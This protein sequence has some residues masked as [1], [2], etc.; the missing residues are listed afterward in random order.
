MQGAPDVPYVFISYASADRER[1]LAVV[2]ALQRAGV[3]VWIDQSGIPGGALYGAEIAAGIEQAAAMILLCTPVSLA[4]RNVRQEIL[5]GWKFQKSYLPLLLEPCEFPKEMSYWLEG[6][7][8]VEV[9]DAPEAVWLPQA[10]A[11]LQR[12]GIAGVAETEPPASHTPASPSLPPLPTI[13]E[14]PPLFGREREQAALRERL[15]GALGGQGGLVLIGGEAGVGKTALTETVAYE[16]TVRGALVLTGR[17][18][19]LT[20]TPP[21]GPWTEI[22]DSIPAA[23]DL[24]PRPSAA[25]SSAASQAEFFREA[26]VFFAALAD[27]RPLVLVLDDMQ[28]ADPASLDML[29]FLSRS[30]ATL[31]ILLVATYRAEDVTRRH[32]FYTLLPILLREAGA[33]RLDLH[34]LPIADVETLVTDRYRLSEADATRLVAYLHERAGGNAFFTQELLRA[35]AEEGVLR[36]ESDGWTVG[37]LAAVQVPLLLRQVIDTRLAR[38]GAEAERLLAL[39]AVIGQTVPLDLWQSVAEADEDTLLDLIE[40]AGEARVLA[41]TADGEGVRFL[42]A[43]IRQALYEGIPAIRRKRL[44]RQIGAVLAER[45]DAHPDTVAYHF[46]RAGDER[47][48]GWLVQAGERAFA[49]YAYASAEERFRR[50]LPHLTGAERATTLLALSY[51]HR[52][53]ESAIADAIESVRAATEAGDTALAALARIRLGASLG[54]IGKIGQ[55]IAEITAANAVLDALPASE[56]ARFD[57]HSYANFPRYAN[58]RSFED[59]R[60]MLT[61]PYAMGGWYAEVLASLGCTLDEALAQLGRLHPNAAAS[62]GFVCSALGRGQDVR[63][64]FVTGRAF[65]EAREDWTFVA[66]YCVYLLHEAY[67]PYFADDPA[68]REQ[69]VAAMAAALARHVAQ[70]GEPPPARVLW[71]LLVLE[72]RWAEARTR[73]GEETD[74]P[75]FRVFATPQIGSLARAQGDREGAWR[76]VRDLLP[77]GPA[78]EPGQTLFMPMTQMQ[79]LAAQLALD[80]GDLPGARGWLEAHDRWLA[81]SGAVRG[82]SEGQLGWAAYHRA[83]ADAERAYE[84]AEH[85]L[86]NA[87]EPR[88]PLALLAAHRLLGELDAEAGR[89]DDAARHLNA[90]LA[91]AIGC[92][93]PYERALTLLAMAEL[94]A[95]TGE[96]ET[97]RML[98]EEARTIFASLDAKPA[99][100][101][102]GALAA[103]LAGA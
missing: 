23:T 50:A 88:Q 74:G 29:R 83:A 93:A 78:T 11:A 97:A 57:S 36:N 7:Q 3:T 92:Q 66:I 28:W 84:R 21:Y 87:T 15:S 45:P 24:P 94:R 65:W 69:I 70:G 41:E 77:D 61:T 32:P 59:G 6:S 13:P 102:A 27:R 43:L 82:Q 34:R 30:V 55:G 10:L 49:S 63:D 58:F 18:Y 100:A 12:V 5:L 75:V 48:A 9:L 42:H 91:L 35:L 60:A 95:A 54:Y 22:R 17:C 67:I 16:A 86:A 14:P 89:H 68:E 39:A 40:R 4:S 71:P 46:E 44:H 56:I 26:L 31:P 62:V 51:L 37:D 98:L 1:A 103:R 85:A 19:D 72:G 101:R 79:R 33:T 47:A 38:L 80:D 64:V 8:W 96:T 2:A 90:S 53:E 76:L 99:L 20:E 25:V 52:H 81:W 73:W